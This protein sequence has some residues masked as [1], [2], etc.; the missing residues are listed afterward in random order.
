MIGGLRI[1]TSDASHSAAEEK[2]ALIELSGR[3]EAFIF[4][5]WIDHV[6]WMTA[7]CMPGRVARLGSTGLRV[8]V[9]TVVGNIIERCRVALGVDLDVTFLDPEGLVSRGVDVGRNSG[10]QKPRYSH[11]S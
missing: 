5:G 3:H 11:Q 6:D 10:G 2:Q 1:V 4:F 7:I 8:A 9:E